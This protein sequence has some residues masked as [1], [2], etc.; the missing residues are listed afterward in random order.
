MPRWLST[1]SYYGFLPDGELLVG[2][3]SLRPALRARLRSLRP[4]VQE[5]LARRDYAGAVRLAYRIL[6]ALADELRPAWADAL[7]SDQTLVQALLVQ[8]ERHPM[9]ALEDM[10]SCKLGGVAVWVSHRAWVV[11]SEEALE[12]A[13]RLVAWSDG[14]VAVWSDGPTVEVR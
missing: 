1:T 7:P 13:R 8:V 3:D 10:T 4:Q 12:M 14:R 9:V 5:A 2:D 6:Q 11:T